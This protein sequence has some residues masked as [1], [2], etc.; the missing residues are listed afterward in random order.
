MVAIDRSAATAQVDL[1][2]WPRNANV[3]PHLM[4]GFLG[5]RESFCKRHFDR[6]IRFC[7]TPVRDRQKDKP[8]YVTTSAATA[9]TACTAGDAD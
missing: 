5:P 3:H 6:F 4:H 1:S 8:R 9:G 2:H 7:T